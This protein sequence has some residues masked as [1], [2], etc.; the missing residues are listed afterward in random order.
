MQGGEL[1]SIT[2]PP[3]RPTERPERTAGNRLAPLAHLTALRESFHGYGLTVT[4]V[5]KHKYGTPTKNQIT[6]TREGLQTA[7]ARGL[8]VKSHRDG[9]A[10]YSPLPT[11]GWQP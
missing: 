10:V 11:D 5:A 8:A 7:V 6:S 1:S 2:K 3:I 4:E 9:V